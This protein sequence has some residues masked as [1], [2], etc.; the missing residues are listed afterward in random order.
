MRQVRE[1]RNGRP[2]QIEDLTKIRVGGRNAGCCLNINIYFFH[3]VRMA[4]G[5]DRTSRASVIWVDEDDSP[6][7][8]PIDSGADPRD[9]PTRRQHRPC[10]S[11]ST[12]RLPDSFHEPE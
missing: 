2:Y 10:A 12:H 6:I 4:R 8:Q 9:L 1:M 5:L 11:P 7:W 3:L